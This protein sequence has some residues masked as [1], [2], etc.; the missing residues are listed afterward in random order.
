MKPRLIVFASGTETGGGSG[1]E[2][3]VAASQGGTL[4]AEIVAVVSNHANGGVRERADRLNVPFV[5]FPAPW[6]SEDYR[7]IVSGFRPDHI[8]LSG[9][10]KMVSGLDPK[11]TFNIHPGPLPRFG[12]PKMFGHHVHKAVL[13][14]YR[15]CTIRHSAVSMH[16]VT[17]EY[18]KGPVFFKM[19]VNVYSDDTVDAVGSRVN[20][21]EHLWQPVITNLVVHGQ[22]SWDGQNPNSLRVPKDYQYL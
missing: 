21:V 5:H 6:G 7:T 14:A 19:P 18:D 10:L 13:A 1:F 17:E 20:N 3:L 22:I 16:F 9:W 2:N 12:G 15:A 4:D 8:A 11:I